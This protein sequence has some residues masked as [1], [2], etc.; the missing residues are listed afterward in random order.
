V[1]LDDLLPTDL[2]GATT[3]M[4]RL[5]AGQSGAMVFR[6]QVS[7]RTFVLKI[8]GEKEPLEPWRKRV[9][10]QRAAAAAGLAP[11]V[12]GTDDGK[13]AVLSEHIVD[14]SFP[15]YFM[16]PATRDAALS[17]LGQTLRRVHDLPPPPG[18]EAKDA[19][20]LLNRTAKGLAKFP[21]PKFVTEAAKRVQGEKPP[22]SD[23]APVLSH[24]DVNPSNLAFDGKRLVLLDWDAAGLNEPYYDLAAIATFLRMDDA[25]CLA[26]LSAHDGAAVTALPARFAYDRRLV[27]VV[28]G[29]MFLQLARDA[30]HAGST[31]E[32]LEST[33]PLADVYQRMRGGQLNLGIPEGK[34]AFG[35]AL[36]QASAA[37]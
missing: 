34:W 19:L 14:Q 23:R 32:T 3:S 36:V 8:S 29:L 27:A 6:I 28:C 17:L 31:S 30:G 20:E 16:T 2:R 26:L 13:R 24:N 35:L 11:T 7:G 15:A 25:T 22:A 33:S 12:V 4:T 21:L 10:I 9:A 1:N 37:L 18:T 5:P